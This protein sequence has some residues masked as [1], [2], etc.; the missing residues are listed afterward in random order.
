MKWGQVM[1]PNGG[2]GTAHPGNVG[3]G[4]PSIDLRGTAM[5]NLSVTVLSADPSWEASDGDCLQL[6]EENPGRTFK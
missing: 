3:L 4:W 6:P 1:A 5:A 2:A